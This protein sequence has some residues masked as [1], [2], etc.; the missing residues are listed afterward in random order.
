[1]S[2]PLA[3]SR[4]PPRPVGR[5]FSGGAAEPPRRPPP[6]GHCA[7]IVLP[8]LPDLLRAPREQLWSAPEVPGALLQT[9]LTKFLQPADFSG[10]LLLRLELRCASQQTCSSNNEMGQSLRIRTRPLQYVRFA[11]IAS[12]SVWTSVLVEAHRHN[13]LSL[14]ILLGSYLNRAV[15]SAVPLPIARI[16]NVFGRLSSSFLLSSTPRSSFKLNRSTDSDDEGSIEVG[17]RRQSR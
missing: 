13:F 12:E 9:L 7:R 10:Y 5:R 6:P 15:D 4:S 14:G 17:G 11:P 16:V 3:A 2:S 1:M 8:A